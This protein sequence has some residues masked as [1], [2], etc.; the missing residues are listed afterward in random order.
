MTVAYVLCDPMRWGKA[1]ISMSVEENTRV[2]SKNRRYYTRDLFGKFTTFSE[3]VVFPDPQNPDKHITKGT[4]VFDRGDSVACVLYNKQ[5][6]V[7]LFTQQFRY[8]VYLTDNKLSVLELLAGSIEDMSPEETMRQE[9][10]EEAGY[11]VEKLIYLFSFH[12]SPGGSTERIHLYLAEYSDKMKVSPGGGIEDHGESIVTVEYSLEDALKYMFET[13]DAKT[14]IGMY[15]VSMY[16][17]NAIEDGD[18][19]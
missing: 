1:D 15:Y 12:V 5:Q 19:K 3:D 16:I 13:P 10:L 6:E 4:F 14:L 7:F 17:A 18:L 9:I 11:N 8:P 2:I